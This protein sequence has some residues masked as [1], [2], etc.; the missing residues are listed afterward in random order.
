MKLQS[1]YLTTAADS[2]L[3]WLLRD[4]LSVLSGRHAANERTPYST[5]TQY[6]SLLIAL[7]TNVVF[8]YGFVRIGLGNGFNA[9]LA[10]MVAAVTLSDTAYVLIGAFEGFSILLGASILLAIYGL[11]DPAFGTKPSSKLKGRRNVS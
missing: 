11:F 2:I 1:V 3:D 4:A 5:P 10:M 8:L 7:S 6:T 9:P